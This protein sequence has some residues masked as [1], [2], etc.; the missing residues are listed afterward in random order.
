MG[1]K[2]SSRHFGEG[3]TDFPSRNGL[4]VE[5]VEFGF[6]K[7]PKNNSHSPADS[8]KRLGLG[9]FASF[10]RGQGAFQVAEFNSP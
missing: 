3:S 1:I 5:L 8:P 7:F 10:S 2:M 6:S 4:A 9:W